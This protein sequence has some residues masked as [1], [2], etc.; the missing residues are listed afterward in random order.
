MKNLL[1]SAA[2]FTASAC[3]GQH[4]Y[5]ISG[6]APAAA[7][8]DTV[9]I[10]KIKDNLQETVGKTTVTAGKFTFSGTA[11]DNGPIIVRAF[12]KGVRN[13]LVATIFTDEGKIN[14]VLDGYDDWYNSKSIVTG[15]PLNDKYNALSSEKLRLCPLMDAAG[16]RSRN[17]SAT[18]KEKASAK[19][20]LDSLS[21]IYYRF[22]SDFVIENIS[23]DAGRTAFKSSDF[24]FMP[25]PILLKTVDAIPAGLRDEPHNAERI[26]FAAAKQ[27]VQPGRPF[28]DFQAPAPDGNIVK[29][30]DF[31]GKGKYVLIDFWASWC[32]PCR[33]AMPELKELYAKYKDKGFE[34]V[35]VSL[36]S[37]K[38]AWLKGISDLQLP[39]PQ[40]SD[41]K[42]WDAAG[43]G[44][45]AVKAVPSTF[46]IGPD[47]KFIETGP[48]LKE[49][50]E[51]IF[52]E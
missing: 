33:A 48:S 12:P 21:N 5:S 9:T 35:G 18:E 2:L 41:T 43:A 10:T 13:G 17:A 38:E 14:V 30:S 34:I 22:L 47:G 15:T 29:L 45:Y 40:M 7:D 50:L 11:E 49:T 19:A 25:L 6:T 52:G 36:D 1:L 44:E 4:V 28:I 3:I 27:A 46:L 51:G 39:W 23:N 20:E 37:R 16:K 24:I 8:G 31:A 32:G 26:R 42:G